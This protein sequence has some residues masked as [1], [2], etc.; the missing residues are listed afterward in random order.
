MNPY[1]EDNLVERPAMELLHT[2]SWDTLNCYDE[3]FGKDGTLGRETSSEVVLLRY[4]R[5]ALVRLN[6]KLDRD[7]I[8]LAVEELTKDRSAMS[9][10]RANAEIY[11]LLKDGV[12][13]TYR[14]D[15]DEDV[16]G[17]VQVIDWKDPANNSFLM[18]NQFWITGS[19]YKRR[20]DIVGFVN[21]IPLVFM[22]LKATHRHIENAYNEN[23]RDYKDTIPQIFW[24]NGFIILSNGSHS[25]IGSM[26]STMEFF[27]EWKKIDSEQEETK[28][29]LEA[30]LRGTCEHTKLLDILENFI[31][32]QNDTIKIIPK[33]IS[34]WELTTP[35]L[36]FRILKTE[37][38][39]LVCFGIHR[40]A[41]KVFLWC[42]LRKRYYAR[43]QGTGHL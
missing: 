15:Y 26:T 9:P 16:D 3:K 22:E 24:Y 39:S 14:D 38:A 31:L 19:V 23:L 36:L 4:L 34:F 37:V 21:G 12:P 42:F 20:A 32:F 27:N 18:A 25:K 30:M 13:V 35:S 7:A 17:Q 41:G 29:S 6:P 33:T 28:V 5:E 40:V 11:K 10:V 43:F 8:D 2:M 1:T